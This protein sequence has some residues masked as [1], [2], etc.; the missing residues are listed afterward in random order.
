MRHRA[1]DRFLAEHPEHLEDEDRI[2]WDAVRRLAQL[3]APLDRYFRFQHRG[4]EHVP[5]GSCLFVVNHSIGAIP[6]ILLLLRAWYQRFGERP[7]RGLAHQVLWQG[8]AKWARI[9]K[10]GAALAHPEV[11]RRSLARGEALVV[12]PGGDAE[13][14][15]PFTDRYKVNLGNRIGFAKL[16]RQTR[17]PI[18]P[19]VLC[20]SHATYIML[21]GAEHFARWS[22]V[23]RF[24]G[25]KAFPLTAGCVGV[26]SAAL[27]TL[28]FPPAFPLFGAA[29]LQSILPLPA[30]I[31]MEVL[32]PIHPRPDETDEE[33]AERVRAA[34]QEAMDRLAAQRKT[35]W[36]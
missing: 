7:A 11:A 31:E 16:A 32:P 15:R 12:F 27:T 33:L 20:G 22:R 1:V 30:R 28:L 24:F 34:M 19:A 5:D 21:P 29:W 2:S 26:L 35:P 17:T 23:G 6:E 4:W 13:T 18:V 25:L 36:W 10:I 9:E 14:C 8:P 3:A